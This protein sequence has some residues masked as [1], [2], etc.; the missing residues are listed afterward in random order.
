MDEEQ[1]RRVRVHTSGAFSQQWE[2]LEG[3]HPSFLFLQVWSFHVL[4]SGPSPGWIHWNW[5]S[6]V[7]NGSQIIHNLNNKKD[8]FSFPGF[9]LF[10]AIVYYF[11]TFIS[12]DICHEYFHNEICTLRYLL[13]QLLWGTDT[14]LVSSTMNFWLL[15]PSQV[16]LCAFLCFS[17][18]DEQTKIQ[19]NPKA[20]PSFSSY[21]NDNNFRVVK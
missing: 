6:A 5:V 20:P 21:T 11:S 1:V 10:P 19:Q 17:F 7:H 18:A 3:E 2:E 9:S 4:S 16:P 8:Y 13:W 12:W 15:A 14:N